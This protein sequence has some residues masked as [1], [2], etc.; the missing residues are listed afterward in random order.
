MPLSP[1]APRQELHLRRVTCRGF[2][3]EDGLWDIEGHMVDTKTY[4]FPNQDRGGEIAAG[5]PIHEM[6]VRVTLDDGYVIQAVEAVT[7]HAPFQ[8]CPAIAPSFASLAGLTLGPGFL[9]ELRRRF[10]GTDGCTHIVE[11]MGPIATTAFQTLAPLLRREGKVDSRPRIIGTCHALAPD[12][13]VVRREW[14]Q[15]YESSE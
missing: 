6:S 5:E 10:A 14:P 9:R 4:G 7:D 2:R 3:R 12:G 15:W 1:P 13:P 8:I 11:L